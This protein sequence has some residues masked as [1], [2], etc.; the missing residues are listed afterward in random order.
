MNIL[1][2]MKLLQNLFF[3][4]VNILSEIHFSTM[5]AIN[6]RHGNSLDY[7]SFPAG[8]AS[9]SKEIR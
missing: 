3:H 8:N 5:T 1:R 9:Q 4:P 2:L 7:T 6:I